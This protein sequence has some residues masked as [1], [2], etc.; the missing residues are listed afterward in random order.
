M[1]EMAMR[2]KTR[3][4]VAAVGRTRRVTWSNMRV[5]SPPLQDLDTVKFLLRHGAEMNNLDHSRDLP[6]HKVI[7][8]QIF[9]LVELLLKSGTVTRLKACGVEM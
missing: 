2:S 1:E 5:A 3:E 9:G 6:L 4:A 8:F 7:I